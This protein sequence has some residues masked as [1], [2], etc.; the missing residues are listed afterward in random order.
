MTP[1]DWAALLLGF[2]VGIGIKLLVEPY[3]KKKKGD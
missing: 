2:W 1:G 3:F